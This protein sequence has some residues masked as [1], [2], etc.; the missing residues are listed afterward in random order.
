MHLTSRVTNTFVMNRIVLDLL[1]RIIYSKLQCEWCIFHFF[2]LKTIRKNSNLNIF[3]SVEYI[4][5]NLIHDIQ[6]HAFNAFS[7]T[8]V[9]KMIYYGY[10]GNIKFCLFPL[11]W[12][13]LCI[14]QHVS[15]TK[16]R[17]DIL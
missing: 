14:F 9:E 11:P 3:R 10:H 17:K 12:K 2:L 6:I 16:F 4:K 8:K 1:F 7:L 15:Y 5:L 13:P